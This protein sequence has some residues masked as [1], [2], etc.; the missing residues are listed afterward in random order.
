MIHY[1][2]VKITMDK[3]D[4]AKIIIDVVVCYHYLFNS[5]MTDGGF[6]FILNVW[7]LLSY[8]LDIKRRLSISPNCWPDQKVE[9]YHESLPK[10]LCQL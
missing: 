1:K 2:L 10:S 6:L 9:Y 4:L 8:F 5:I 7:S 3:P